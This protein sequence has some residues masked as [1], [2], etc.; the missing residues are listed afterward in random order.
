MHVINILNYIAIFSHIAH[1]I[2]LPKHVVQ[3]FVHKKNH[4]THVMVKI[5]SSNVNGIQLPVYVKISIIHVGIFQVQIV[6]QKNMVWIVYGKMK[7]VKT[8]FVQ[9]QMN[10]LVITFLVPFQILQ[11]V[12]IHIHYQI[13][14]HLQIKQH[15]IK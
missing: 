1:G 11:D 12:V 8:M 6:I 7:N 13:V 15:V 14:Q 3:L 9:I 2:K 10:N 4:Q 5:L